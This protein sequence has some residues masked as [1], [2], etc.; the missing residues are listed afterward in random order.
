MSQHLA[1]LQ[2]LFRVLYEQLLY[3]IFQVR[4]VVLPS[5][6]VK[7]GPLTQSLRN[8]LAHIARKDYLPSHD[9]VQ[10]DA[11]AVQ[12]DLAVVGAIDLECLGSYV[13]ISPE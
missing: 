1:Y 5:L 6:L 3:Q 11:E 13:A 2:A 8:D 7:L 12:I 10:C 4:R 9:V